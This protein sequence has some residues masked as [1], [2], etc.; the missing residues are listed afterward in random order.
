LKTSSSAAPEIKVTAQLVVLPAVAALP[1]RITLPQGPL[2]TAISPG[3]TIR[4]NG[5]NALV[6]SGASVNVPGAEVRVQEIQTN[7]LFRVTVNFPAGFEIQPDQK[8]ELSVKSNHA[9]FPVIRVPV[10]PSN[11]PV[12]SR[13]SS[14]TSS[15]VETR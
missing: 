2:G 8:I 1:N 13:A 15:L 12:V 10:S 14:G 3:V 6:L 11:R 7:R 4:N 5:T 9:N